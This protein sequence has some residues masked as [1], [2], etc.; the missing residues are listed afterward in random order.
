MAK[1]TKRKA[2][3]N[4]KKSRGKKN[5]RSGKLIAIILAFLGFLFLAEVVSYIVGKTNSSKEIFVQ[6][7]LDFSGATQSCGA[8]KAWDV[9]ALPD[10][11][12]VLSDQGN[13]RLLFFDS[14]GQFLQ[15]IGLKQAG[16]PDL[17]EVSCLTADSSGN[18]YVMDTWTGLIRGFDPKGRAMV[19]VDLGGKG[20]YGPRGLA[21]DGANFVIADT[22]SHRVVKVTTAGSILGAWGQHGSG[23]K[24]FQNP[25][26]V[27]A[28]G[29]GRYEV[30]DRDNNRIQILDNEG[31]FL[32]QIDLGA[33]PQAEAVDAARH[34]LYVS[35][36]DGRFL[37]AYGLD[38]NLIGNLVQGDPKNPQPLSGVNALSVLPNGDIVASMT[39]R[40]T[41]YHSLPAAPGQR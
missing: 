8:F 36:L 22:G 17:T 29:Q 27:V 37:R 7:V 40:I 14:K 20:F 31:H 13:K 23:N 11:R 19:K 24:E 10:G 21:W 1:I 33:P 26:Q 18:V 41:V 39:D 28:D 38:G 3:S 2:S 35:S 12:I 34:I 15:E 16:P 25:Y 32:K 4:S 6:D 5:R 30:V 9:L